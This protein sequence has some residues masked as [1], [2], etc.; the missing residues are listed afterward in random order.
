MDIGGF[1]RRGQ[2]SES[3]DTRRISKWRGHALPRF[4]IRY[5]SQSPSFFSYPYPYAPPSLRKTFVRVSVGPWS[6][7][8]AWKKS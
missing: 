3:D 5:S 2:T 1:V 4:I 6:L 7:T 8:S